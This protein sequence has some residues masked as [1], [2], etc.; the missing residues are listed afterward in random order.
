MEGVKV[1]SFAITGQPDAALL[2]FAGRLDAG[3]IAVG[4]HGHMLGERLLIGSTT[5]ALLAETTRPV[6]VMPPA[7]QLT[8]RR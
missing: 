6:L 8:T 4:R 1:G 3:F 2:D 5:N 7:S